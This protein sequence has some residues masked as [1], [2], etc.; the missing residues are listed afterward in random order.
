MLAEMG[1]MIPSLRGACRRIEH[2]SILFE[3]S[4]LEPLAYQ[5]DEVLAGYALFEHPDQP[6]VTSISQ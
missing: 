6:L 5:P 1:E 2:G 3:Y 4:R